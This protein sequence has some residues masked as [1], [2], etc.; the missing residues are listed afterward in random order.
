MKFLKT[1]ALSSMLC[2][3]LPFAAEANQ[4]TIKV[5]TSDGK[6]LPNIYAK[7][8]EGNTMG[9][10]NNGTL[11]FDFSG[12]KTFQLSTYETWH[13]ASP[14]QNTWTS[15]VTVT[16]DN[17]NTVVVLDPI[18]EVD[19]PE[20]D[21]AEQDMLNLLNQERIAI[22]KAPVQINSVLSGLAAVQATNGDIR[23]PYRT[24][25]THNGLLC[26]SFVTRAAAAGI[27]STVNGWLGENITAGSS[28]ASEAL[29]AWKNEPGQ[30]H[31]RSLTS[32]QTQEVGIA[33]VG[34]VWVV[35][36]A[37]SGGYTTDGSVLSH[38]RISPSG[39]SLS[40]KGESH[41]DFQ[42]K[43]A[44]DKTTS[45]SSPKNKLI[46]SAKRKKNT[47]VIK[48]KVLPR[49][50][51][52]ATLALKKNGKV[53]SKINIQIGKAGSFTKKWNKKTKRGYKLKLTVKRENSFDALS[54]TLVL[55]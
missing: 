26:E 34:V 33:R 37:K 2:L 51:A 36:V 42:S 28:N 47:L 1:L 8:A 43:E 5:Q 29:A 16:D 55:R 46:L 38:H 20:I 23:G 41:P 4:G 14:C 40:S 10:Y 54:K 39:W 24:A 35:V 53:V 6:P 21:P 22:G 7:D 15:S 12:Q 32:V 11:T 30:D 52:K 27:A 44:S 31:W 48:G 50:K 13:G 45:V 17:P 19:Q 49:R 25:E 18:F 3:A 9:T